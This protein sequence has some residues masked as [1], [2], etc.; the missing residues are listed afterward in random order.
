MHTLS[1]SSHMAQWMN[2]HKK[3]VVSK[4]VTAFAFQ[5]DL[6]ILSYI[7]HTQVLKIDPLTNC[8]HTNKVLIFILF[9]VFDKA[10]HSCLDGQASAFYSCLSFKCLASQKAF[11]I[12]PQQRCVWQDILWE[13]L[14][15]LFGWMV[16]NYNVPETI[17]SI[18]HLSTWRVSWEISA[19]ERESLC[20]QLTLWLG[21]QRWHMA[22][23]LCQ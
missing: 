10:S 20:A 19:G 18:T 9:S 11:T 4:Y 17:C 7:F 5:S 13:L 2:P 22:L 21:R 16:D 3:P 12:R 6:E 14:I 8:T 15:G 23:L 1:L